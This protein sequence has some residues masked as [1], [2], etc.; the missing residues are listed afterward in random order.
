VV[1]GLNP[2]APASQSLQVGDVIEEVNQQPVRSVEDFNKA[3][4][5]IPRG[6]RALLFVCRGQTRSF[7]VITP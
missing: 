5:E 4:A 3:V 1:S 2:D 6:E 7:V